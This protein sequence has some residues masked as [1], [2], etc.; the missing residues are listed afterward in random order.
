MH[1]PKNSHYLDRFHSNESMA[2]IMLVH[3]FCVYI[4]IEQ[5]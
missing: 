3:R 5:L 1:W 4:D 2:D